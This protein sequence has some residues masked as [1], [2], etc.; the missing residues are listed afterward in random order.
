MTMVVQMH[1]PGYVLVD[2]IY[3]CRVVSTNEGV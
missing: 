3:K 2:T 1:R